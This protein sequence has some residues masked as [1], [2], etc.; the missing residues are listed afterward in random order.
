MPRAAIYARVSTAE[1]VEGHSIDAQIERLR[2]YAGDHGFRLAGEYVDPGFQGDTDDRPALRRLMAHARAREFEIVLVYRFDRIFREVR[3]FLNTEHELRQHGVRLISITEAIDDTHEGRLQLLIKGSFAEYEKAVI[4][5]RSNLG[6]IRAAKEGK[7]MGGPPPYGYDLNPDTSR[8]V[9]NEEEAKWVQKFYR[10]LV[11]DRLSL[12]KLQ[13]RVNDLKAPT[14][15]EQL[16]R[17]RPVNRGGWW[18]QRTLGRILT[19]ELYTGT[20]HYRKVWKPRAVRRKDAKLR[21]EE[22]WIAIPVPAI[23]DHD[24]FKFAQRQL[25]K[26]SELSPR[27]TNRL[28]LLRRLVECGTCGRTWVATRNNFDRPYYIC[29][30]RRKSASSERCERPA[31]MASALEPAVWNALIELLQDPALVL[32]KVRERLDQDGVREAKDRELREL[33][34]QVLK[35]EHEEARL[36]RAFKEGVID[37]QTLKTEREETRERISR[38]QDARNTLERELTGWLSKEAQIAAV[39]QLGHDVIH[40]LP[41]VPYERRCEVVRQVVDRVVVHETEAEVY[42]VLPAGQPIAL[43]DAPGVDRIV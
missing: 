12:A 40:A 17:N 11:D 1:Q 3:L 14:K 38:L 21:P 35:A 5:E 29:S 10:W 37:L 9:V 15:W 8:L 20:Y 27:R 6:R 43:Q 24:L 31:V 30:G 16:R 32:Q 7:W 28:Y 41:N 42:T 34:A 18:M 2:A 33:T 36:I 23:I 19:K 22:E 13:R 39:E 25:K 4:R 26:N